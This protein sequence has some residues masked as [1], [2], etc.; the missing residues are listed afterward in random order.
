MVTYYTDFAY[1][2]EEMVLRGKRQKN[3]HT[4]LQSSLGA[5]IQDTFLSLKLCTPQ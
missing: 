2:K 3:C 5:K 1:L 4:G